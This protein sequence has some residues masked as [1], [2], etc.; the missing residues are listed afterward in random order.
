MTGART[1]ESHIVP[2]IGKAA[3]AAGRPEPRIVAGLPIALVRDAAAAREA[4]AKAFEI[5]GTLPSY[6]AI[7]RPRGRGRA[8]RRRARGRRGRAARAGR[9]AARRGVTDFDAAVAPVEAGSEKRTLEFLASL[10]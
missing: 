9:A 5:Y 4:V 6:R 2:A 10:R 3:R 8:R 1:L 7:A